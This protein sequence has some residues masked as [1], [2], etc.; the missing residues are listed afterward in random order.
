M[1][2]EQEGEWGKK[3]LMEEFYG[4]LVEKLQGFIG[5]VDFIVFLLI[6]YI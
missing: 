1:R 4:E 5:F 6:K 3:D 2:D